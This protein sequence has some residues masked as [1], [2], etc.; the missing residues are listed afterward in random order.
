MGSLKESAKMRASLFLVFSFIATLSGKHLLIETADGNQK[1]GENA[2]DYTDV[3]IPRKLVAELTKKE[4]CFPHEW[5]RA[6]CPP[7]HDTKIVNEDFQD[8]IITKDFRTCWAH[9]KKLKGEKNIGHNCHA[10]TFDKSTRTCYTFKSS[11]ICYQAT[12]LIPNWVS[13]QSCD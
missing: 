12:T 11:P 4:E 10:W 3:T 5:E 8:S 9:C 7:H 1:P 6:A 13:G 2:S